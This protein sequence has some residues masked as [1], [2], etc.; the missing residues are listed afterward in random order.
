MLQT[1]AGELF[2]TAVREGDLPKMEDFE[3]GN[4]NA[5]G[6]AHSGQERMPCP[7]QSG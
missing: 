4:E 6:S 2:G 7:V 3:M 1:R 5:R